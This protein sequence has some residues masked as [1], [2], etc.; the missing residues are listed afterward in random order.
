MVNGSTSFAGLD[1][2]L[3]RGHAAM[4]LG[5]LG[6]DVAPATSMAP[7]PAGP[8]SGSLSDGVFIAR[9]AGC[10]PGSLLL[11]RQR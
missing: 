10:S 2:R 4:S 8:Q 1:E 3:S 5:I 9:K 7:Y 6:S 11:L